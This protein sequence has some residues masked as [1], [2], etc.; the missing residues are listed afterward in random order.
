[1]TSVLAALTDRCSQTLLAGAQNGGLPQGTREAFAQAYLAQISGAADEADAANE[2][3]GN[4]AL[5]SAL[6]HPTLR[7]AARRILLAQL[8]KTP[9]SSS[10]AGQTDTAATP[11][12]DTEASS[13]R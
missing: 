10:P 9:R 4:R 7:P 5:Y 6:A 2:S 3:P 13:P 12:T 8:Q 1:M 11:D